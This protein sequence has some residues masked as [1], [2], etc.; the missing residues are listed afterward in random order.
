VALD[1]RRVLAFNP[2]GAVIDL[3]S[4]ALW[5]QMSL[6]ALRY[7]R[8]RLA[9][10]VLASAIADGCKDAEDLVLAIVQQR[11]PAWAE[12][13]LIERGVRTGELETLEELME[14]SQLVAI[15]ERAAYDQAMAAKEEAC[16][17]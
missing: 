14:I 8:D 17:R 7:V 15:R 9:D 4:K 1:S 3:V 11:S 10:E 6:T 16:S 5:K 12:H 13:K 2:G